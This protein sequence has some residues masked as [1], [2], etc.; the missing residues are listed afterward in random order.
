[1]IID[2]NFFYLFFL[3][4]SS[5]LL[6]T[7]YPPTTF[8]VPTKTAKNAIIFRSILSAFAAIIIAPTITIPWIAL[9]AY[10]KGVCKIE[11]TLLINSNPN[12]IASKNIYA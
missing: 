3:N 9:V 1:M 8:K 5:I 12:I 4:F 2:Y 7:T 11:G 10:I 6:V